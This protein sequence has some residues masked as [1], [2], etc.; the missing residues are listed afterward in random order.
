MA[1]AFT[2]AHFPVLR[3]TRASPCL[4]FNTA[5]L[6][7]ET[8][9]LWLRTDPGAGQAE[10][11]GLPPEWI[12]HPGKEASAGAG[13]ATCE[14]MWSPREVGTHRHASPGTPSESGRGGSSQ[15]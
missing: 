3:Q 11:G 13:E 1:C 14:R 2:T 12:G 5:L 7:P 4:P 8:A 10:E 6:L 15:E 9:R